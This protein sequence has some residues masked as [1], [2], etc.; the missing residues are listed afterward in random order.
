M[1]A[2]IVIFPYATMSPMRQW[3]IKCKFFIRE[4]GVIEQIL[5][6]VPAWPRTHY[7]VAQPDLELMGIFPHYL[8]K[9]WYYRYETLHLV[10]I[11]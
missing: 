1:S 4:D 11:K 6:C 8:F 3:T 9:Y 5:L 2:N 10:K 7:Y